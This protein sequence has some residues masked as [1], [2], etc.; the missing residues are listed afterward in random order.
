MFSFDPFSADYCAGSFAIDNAILRSAFADVN[1]DNGLYGMRAIEN[2]GDTDVNAD[3]GLFD[4]R[5][6]AFEQMCRDYAEHRAELRDFSTLCSPRSGL[7]VNSL[8]NPELSPSTGFNRLANEFINNLRCEANK[9]PETIEIVVFMGSYDHGFGIH[10]DAKDVTAF[11]LD[12][13]KSFAIRDENGTTLEFNLSKGQYMRWRSINWHGNRNPNHEWSITV[14]FTVGPDERREVPVGTPVDY[15]H[16]E[17]RM[18][19][20]LEHMLWERSRA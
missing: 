16:S 17:T 12:G 9:Y 18:K 11:V 10:R 3:I 19:S 4:P 1:S 20:L 7:V 5:R 6:A 15:V 13:K 8:Q 2:Q 14:N